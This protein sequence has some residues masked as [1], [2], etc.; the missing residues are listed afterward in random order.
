MNVKLT[1]GKLDGVHLRPCKY[2]MR[3]SRVG[4]VVGTA[5]FEKK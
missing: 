4:T 1:V 2:E 5:L 3:S